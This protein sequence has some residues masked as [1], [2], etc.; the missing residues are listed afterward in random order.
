[1]VVSG[2]LCVAV[3]S[4]IVRSRLSW[5]SL[6]PTERRLCPVEPDSAGG[7]DRNGAAQRVRGSSLR[8]RGAR[9]HGPRRTG[10]RA[11]AVRCF[12]FR[13]LQSSS[14]LVRTSAVR[15]TP[16]ALGPRRRRGDLPGSCAVLV[17]ADRRT[18]LHGRGVARLG[19]AVV[20]QGV[21]RQCGVARPRPHRRSW[22]PTAPCRVTDRLH[23][24]AFPP[25]RGG[26]GSACRVP[27][28]R[29]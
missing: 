19:E 15:V 5:P 11:P 18:R 14:S 9:G 16:G 23:V 25:E 4:A 27:R 10:V 28:V 21:V 26:E 24:F 2:K 6:F 20:E 29:F 13:G 17:F 7:E 3:A 1:M 22:P 12:A 8:A